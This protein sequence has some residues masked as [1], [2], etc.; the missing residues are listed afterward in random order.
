[1]T[2]DDSQIRHPQERSRRI[3][4]F[5]DLRDS[6][7]IMLNYEHNR[8]QPDPED[9]PRIT[10]Y[11]EFLLDYHKTAFE[12][13]Y[14]DHN[15][16]HTE[17]YGDGL[18]AIFPEDNAKYILE[19]VYELTSKMRHY[20]LTENVG[21]SKPAID[22]GFGLTIGDVSF[23]F[24]QLDQRYHP[25]G[26]AIHEAARIEAL[27]RYYDARVLIS[28]HFYHEAKRWIKSDPRFECRFIDRVRL[29]GFIEPVSIYELLIDND[30]R[31][32][33]KKRSAPIFAEAYELY[34]Q[35]K[36]EEAHN[37]FL[38]VYLEFG[39]GVGDV[40]A[41]RCDLLMQTPPDIDEWD[42]VWKMKNK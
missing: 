30:P 5:C 12:H 34:C 41:K 18:M 39:L 20:N 19:N 33:A 14:L 10:T 37:L 27:S 17:I 3:I 8:Y 22:M 32:N 13:L 15:R 4:L 36:W 1:M 16:T 29:K 38:R 11:G 25:I 35:R 26:T 24:Y 31:F 2:I 9:R 28:E 21:I 42:G 23:T 7:D 6:T 40:M